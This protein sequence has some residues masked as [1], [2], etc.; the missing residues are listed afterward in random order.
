[1]FKSIDSQYFNGNCKGELMLIQTE[2]D[3]ETLK[4]E[5]K[6]GNIY[7]IARY[8][9]DNKDDSFAIIKA[10]EGDNIL[11]NVYDCEDFNIILKDVKYTTNEWNWD[12]TNFIILTPEEARPYLQE[13]MLAT[14]EN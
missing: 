4:K 13:I 9:K 6:K 10:F 7:N 1:M 3:V 5:F 2:P 12:D 14:L 8:R 11:Y